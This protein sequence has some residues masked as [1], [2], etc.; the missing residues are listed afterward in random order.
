MTQDTGRAPW[1][2]GRG[3][4]L[5]PEQAQRLHADLRL[6]LAA[7][8]GFVVLAV[9]AAVA[10]ALLAQHQHPDRPTRWPLVIGL[11]VGMVVLLA[12][13]LALGLRWRARHQ[14]TRRYLISGD[15]RARVR[16]GKQLRKG[17]AIDDQDREVAVATVEIIQRQWWLPLYFLAMGL[18]FGAFALVD[19]IQ[20]PDQPLLMQVLR[21]VLPLVMLTFA[22]LVH[23]QRRR[24]LANAARQ[25]LDGGPDPSSSRSRHT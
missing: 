22:V 23:Q 21:W 15:R 11:A 16:V 17:Q 2:H 5:T 13:T 10:G 1:W 19:H 3:E 25:G 14:P 8:V 20:R 24:V 4:P 6:R 9:V 12:A 18:V 7:G